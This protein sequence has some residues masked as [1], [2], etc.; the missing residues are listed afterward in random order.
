[1]TTDK[2]LKYP[3]R[4]LSEQGQAD[5][6]RIYRT[7]GPDTKI[8]VQPTIEQALLQ[9]KEIG[10]RNGG[11]QTLITGSLFLVGGALR[12]LEPKPSDVLA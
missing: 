1:M 3:D 2:S 10:D 5:Y 6:A 11:M 12:L 7:I 9:A 8:S 4:F